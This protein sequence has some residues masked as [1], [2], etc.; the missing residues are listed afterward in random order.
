MPKVIEWVVEEPET[1]NP[2][3]YECYKVEGEHIEHL[4]QEIVS[5]F[6][7]VVQLYDDNFGIKGNTIQAITPVYN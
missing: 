5:K 3:L 2:S 1:I 7:F 4:P 6:D